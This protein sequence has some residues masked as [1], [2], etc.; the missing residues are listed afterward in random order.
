M[1][2]CITWHRSIVRGGGR[3]EGLIPGAVQTRNSGGRLQCRRLVADVAIVAA[4][5][6]TQLL[7]ALRE[8]PP[9]QGSLVLDGDIIGASLIKGLCIDRP[10]IGGSIL[11]DRWSRRWEGPYEGRLRLR[12]RVLGRTESI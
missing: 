10:C 2:P 9:V 6:A 1:S 7:T 3:W 5:G 4:A 12:S 11:S 8:E